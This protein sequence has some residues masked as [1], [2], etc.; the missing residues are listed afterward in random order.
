MRKNLLPYYFVLALIFQSIIGYSQHEQ[1]N[2][3]SK[4]QHSL[5]ENLQNALNQLDFNKALLI[6]DSIEH[7]GRL[8]DDILF[9]SY[10][11]SAKTEIYKFKEDIPNAK[12]YLKKIIPIFKK[13]RMYS[14]WTEQQS[15]YASLLRKEGKLDSSFLV[16]NQLQPFISD[17]L[18]KRSLKYFY[19]IKETSF[20]SSGQID[21]T[22]H[23]IYK[24][25]DL[26][27]DDNNY[28]LGN[29]YLQLSAVFYKV[30]DYSKALL[31][32]DKAIEQTLG[33]EDKFRILASKNHIAKSNILI[34]LKK[35]TEAETEAEKALK[36]LKGKNSVEFFTKARLALAGI[37]W[38]TQRK[39]QSKDIINAIDFEGLSNQTQYDVLLMSLKQYGHENNWKKANPIIAKLDNLT[40][41][42]S[43]LNSKSTFYKLSADIWSAQNESKKSIAA[44]NE[45]QN[46]NS[47]INTMQRTYMVYDLEKKYQVE[48]KD[49]E[50]LAQQLALQ[51]SRDQNIFG[52]IAIFVLLLILLSFF[53]VYRQRQNIKNKQIAT[54][55]AQQN[56]TR[57]EA[58]I[59]GEEK[60]RSRLAQEL[61]D[62]I[63]GDLSVLKYKMTALD[64][65]KFS[66][67]DL[68]EYKASIN[69]LDQTVEQIRQIS[70]NLIPPS[71]NSFNLKEAIQQYCLKINNAHDIDIKFQYYGD[72]FNFKK[73]IEIVIYRI[74]QEL[75]NNIIKHAQATEAIVQINHHK[76]TIDITIED[77]GIGFS[78]TTNH[79][80]IGLKNIAHRTAY[81]NAS[82]DI[83][84]GTDGTSVTISIDL[85]KL[86]ND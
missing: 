25:I 23:Y 9:V 39:T 11:Y 73:N 4:K 69:L 72:Q 47:Q 27:D 56:L 50:I 18:E 46:L 59:E 62:G 83:N 55:E 41:E 17:T 16:L 84:S 81:L 77:N 24:R 65:S 13:L 86:P 33:N 44:Q 36:L 76:K 22:I 42:I 34:G 63:N 7:Y 28:E 57:L 66:N 85:E 15:A 2:F 26:I 31:Y 37:Y 52:G 43:S 71:L 79:G 10:G 64:Y 29:A 60:E 12:R 45:F 67:A 51:K 6:A 19:N 14:R 1:G 40:P 49:N 75:I 3:K 78:T 8:H 68:K 21:S 30:S 80:G 54:L 5:S 74:V 61:H 82:L 20:L 32:I 48:K 38:K 53:I 35:F 58:L 70:H